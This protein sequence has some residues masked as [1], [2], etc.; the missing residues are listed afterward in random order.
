MYLTYV[1]GNGSSFP[2]IS[3]RRPWPNR[4]QI[5]RVPSTYITLELTK[6]VTK[7]LLFYDMMAQATSF[8]FQ[9]IGLE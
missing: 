7:L 2:K 6:S 9:I 4:D 3:F 1:Y 8:Y 5:L